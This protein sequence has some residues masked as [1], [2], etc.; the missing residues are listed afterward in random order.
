MKNQSIKIQ[1]QSEIIN[2]F[3]V[4]NNDIQS[5][6]NAILE[7][8]D[9]KKFQHKPVI[10]QIED[11]NFQANELA[12]LVEILT[13]NDIVTIGVRTLKTELIDFA[14]FSGLAV[15]SK[16]SITNE[17]KK[18]DKK[19]SKKSSKKISNTKNTTKN[20]LPKLQKTAP[21]IIANKVSSA[22]QILAENG[23]LVLLESVKINAEVIAGGSIFAYKD[24]HGKV[25]AGS[26]GDK[27]SSIFIQSFN[28]QLVSIAGVY[29]I[30]ITVPEKL[31]GQ[32]VVVDLKD[33]KLRFKIV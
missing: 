31:R 14:K 24:L 33:E 9:D 6:S 7:L 8:A 28:P 25:F 26:A 19:S 20:T 32:A 27:K 11:E 5:L 23:D 22:T 21:K 1:T 3:R 15:F 10:L 29:K 18:T 16:A 30:F 17:I 12:I 13:Q 2:T 4:L